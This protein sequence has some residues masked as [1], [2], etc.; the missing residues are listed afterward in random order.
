MILWND[1]AHGVAE[2]MRRDSD[3]LAAAERDP[4]WRP[5][6]RLFRFDPPGITL[7]RS[8]HPERVLDLERCARDAVAFAVRPTGGR[9]IFHAEEWTY[10]LTA[11]LDDPRFGGSLAAAYGAA[12]TLIA[13]SLR[14]LGIAADLTP[15]RRTTS[16]QGAMGSAPCFASTAAHEIV[17]EGRKL[18]GSA[19]RRTATALLQQGSILL[20][21]GH[22]RLADYL[23]LPDPQRE[24]ARVR[25]ERAS[26]WAAP[27]GNAT[28]EA[29]ADSLAAEL[30]SAAFRLTGDAALLT[31]LESGSILRTA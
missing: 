13:G 15:G 26:T 24:A 1:G 31:L 28:R 25:L 20:G 29:W 5:V 9:A 23:A 4:G 7:G 22:L 14:R 12:S 2:N 30:G 21:P 3:L 17:L 11:R 16:G 10:S 18:A 19:Q 27:P 6:L 8:Q